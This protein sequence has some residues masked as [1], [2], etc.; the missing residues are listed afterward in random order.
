MAWMATACGT[1]ITPAAP[2]VVSPWVTPASAGPTPC[3]IIQPPTPWATSRMSRPARIAMAMLG[4][5]RMAVNASTVTA[6]ITM[7]A[8]AMATPP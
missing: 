3:W 1:F 6:R 4:K 5:A 2:K 7:A 8:T